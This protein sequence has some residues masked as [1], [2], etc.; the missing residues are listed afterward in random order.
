MGDLLLRRPENW[1]DLTPRQRAFVSHPSVLTDPEQ[2]AR[3]SGFSDIYAKKHAD[4][5]RRELR[6]FIGNS[7]VAGVARAT[8]DAAVVL[9]ELTAAALSNILD[10]FELT[11]DEHGTRLGMKQNLKVLPL[12]VQRNIKKLEFDT[13]V[14][15]DGTSITYVSNI[16]LHDRKWALKEFVEIMR[17]RDGGVP[18][19][20]G[21]ELLKHMPAQ[22]LEALDA[23]YRRA[24]ERVES[25]RKDRNA[26]STN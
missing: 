2:A 14:L 12:E 21:A 5:L 22:D 20:D 8:M 10:Y 7:E 13:I 17:L 19:G 3:D 16:E 15:P 26:I 18:A 24:A 6:R 1:D 11:E 23:I 25:E 4:S 9:R